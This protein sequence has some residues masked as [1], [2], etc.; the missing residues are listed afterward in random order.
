MPNSFT[1]E[2]TEALYLLAYE[3]GCK[4]LTLFRDGCKRAGILTTHE[5]EKPVPTAGEG[6]NRGDIV[7]IDD[8]VIGKKRKLITGCG[9]LHCMAFFDPETGASWK[10]ISAKGRQ[11]AA[12]TS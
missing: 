5:E 8:N 4:G 10:R 1:V 11:G 6:L 7:S 9:S 12:I 2:D 3:K